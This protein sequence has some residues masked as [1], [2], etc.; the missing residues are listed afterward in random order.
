ME[1]RQ[2]QLLGPTTPSGR[3]GPLE[4]LHAKSGARKLQRGRQAVGAGTNDDGVNGVR[5]GRAHSASTRDS[6]ATTTPGSVA[7]R[8]AKA[9][10]DSSDLSG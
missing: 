4:D 6:V 10:R 5:A 1:T 2:G 3:R 9:S 8:S 7:K